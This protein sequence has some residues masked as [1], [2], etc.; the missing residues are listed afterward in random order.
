M[1]KVKSVTVR[2]VEREMGGAV[3]NPRTRWRK[4]VML[5]AFVEDGAGRLGVG[6]AWLNE[7]GAGAAKSVIEDD[8]AP[9]VVGRSPFRARGLTDIVARGTEISG[10]SGISGA[11][12]GAVDAALW[13]LAARQLGIAL[14]DLLGRAHDRVPVYA[15]AGLYGEGKTPDRLAQEVSGWVERGF[16]AVKIKVGGAP[17]EEDV[18]RIA[19][20]RE[21]IGPHVRFMI[22]A[23]YNLDVAGALA[24][25]RA[26]APY[27]IT[28]LEAP[29][30]PFDVKGQGRVAKDS[31]I[32]ICGNE[33]MAWG[34]YFRDLIAADAVHF[35]QYDI[36]AC[37][38]VTEGKR[39]G[40]YA[41]IH[42]LPAT[43]HASSSSV[44]YAASLHLAAS[45]PNAHSVEHHML[46]QWFWDEA[47]DG[48]FT[49]QNG[50]LA[51]PPGPGIGVA[52]T[53]DDV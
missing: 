29:V 1:E 31:P 49:P 26:A 9:L 2:V 8:L 36:A 25:A 35:V 10:R 53:P 6:E 5:F 39:I 22:D 41:H 16:D 42:H 45:L 21:A 37:G 43:L 20:V 18:R 48:T 11:A 40:E 52:L 47:P 33:S 44:L 50:T 32:P 7:G 46:H 51:P 34:H 3:W 38:G 19:A 4:K 15:S 23:L 14:A 17:L 24:L 12:W 13:D 27:D 30:S 28:F